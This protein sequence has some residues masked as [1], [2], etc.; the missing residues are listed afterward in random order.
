MKSSPDSKAD[1]AEN[2]DRG[3]DAQARH[4]KLELVRPVA[5]EMPVG[6]DIAL[7]VKVSDAALSDLRGG[8]V[9]IVMAERGTTT[10]PLADYRDGHNETE[11]LVVK[12]PA[13]LGEFAWV[14]VFPRQEIDG[15]AYEERRLPL[16]FKTAP[17][18]TSLAVWDVPSPVR[19]GDGFRI[20][21]GA[22]SSGGCALG[23]AKVEVRDANDKAVG[24]GTLG[25]TPW[26]DTGALYWTEIALTAPRDDGPLS[27]SVVFAA[28][29]PKLPHAG[30]STTFSFTAVKPPAH[31]LTVKAIDTESA[32]PIEDVLVGL[33]PYRA[34]TDGAG[35]ANIAAPAGRYNLALWNAAF[36]VAPM[37]VELNADTLVQVELKRLPEEVKGWG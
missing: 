11:E 1:L 26:P 6:A 28:Q 16:A 15:L 27:W 4:V 35:L 21:V 14:L 30:A 8:L 19:I 5:A 7:Q 20:K 13:Q 2:V 9:E 22:K 37:T 18:R 36:E 29:E 25:E 12:A 10:R 3:A 24:H 34:A 32:T 33:G 17:H 31:Q 23:G